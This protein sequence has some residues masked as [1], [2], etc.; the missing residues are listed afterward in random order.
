[1]GIVRLESG[2]GG[3]G[4]DAISVAFAVALPTN[5]AEL[6]LCGLSS[7]AKVKSSSPPSSLLWQTVLDGDSSTGRDFEIA[8]TLVRCTTSSRSRFTSSRRLPS[9]SVCSTSFRMIP[10]AI[11]SASIARGALSIGAG[12]MLCCSS[13]DRRVSSAL[14]WYSTSFRACE[15]SFSDDPSYRSVS[16]ISFM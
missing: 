8:S 15:S 16:E 6:V 9:S 14:C 11:I 10:D 3:G 1:M 12:R 7:S 2:G 5:I 4:G 13:R